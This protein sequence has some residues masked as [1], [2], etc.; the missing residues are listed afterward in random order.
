M[1][2]FLTD[3]HIAKMHEKAKIRLLQRSPKDLYFI[4]NP[5]LNLVKIGISSNV[6]QRLNNLTNSVGVDLKLI[7]FYAGFGHTEQA[8]HYHFKK[9]RAKGEWFHFTG[10]LVKFVE[11][12]V[13]LFSQSD[14]K[15]FLNCNALYESAKPQLV[16]INQARRNLYNPKDP[17][18]GK[19]KL[20]K[21][22]RYITIYSGH[23]ENG[24]KL[25]TRQTNTLKVYYLKHLKKYKADFSD[26]DGNILIDMSKAVEVLESAGYDLENIIQK[27]R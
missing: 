20:E 22:N 7:L 13:K 1:S 23:K 17:K 12:Q 5:Q 18:A 6:S 4:F 26:A 27:V 24:A 11:E 15:A 3:N 21:L 8:L 25:Q 16:L 9:L 2:N 14:F 19:Y 10:E